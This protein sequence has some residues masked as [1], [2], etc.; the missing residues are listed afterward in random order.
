DGGAQSHLI[1]APASASTYRAVLVPGTAPSLTATNK[2]ITEG[3]GASTTLLF[4]VKLSAATGQSVSV[5]YATFDKSAKAGVDYTAASGT[6]T[7]APGVTSV[8]VP[9]L[10]TGDA[11][12]EPDESL[13]IAL[14]DPVNATIKTASAVG[15][16]L[17][18]DPAPSIAIADVTVTET[19]S[20]VNAVFTVTLSAASGK[21]VT[22]VYQTSSGSATSGADFVAT[23]GTL[24]FA[25]GS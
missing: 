12:D 25:R 16:V 19:D 21:V 7:F 14:S 23:A 1:V 24:T 9:V 18:D 20:T 17:D 8:N 5:R 11:M 4:T 22:V 3:T 15:T 13:G 2:T 10:V 6:V